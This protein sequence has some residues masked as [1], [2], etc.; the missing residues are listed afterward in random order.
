MRLQS[1]HALGGMEGILQA[2]VRELRLTEHEERQGIVGLQPDGFLCRNQ[3]I[4]PLPLVAKR[5]AA[6]PVRP[7][8]I[9]GQRDSARR[10]GCA[11]GIT[12]QVEKAGGE[13]AADRGILG[14]GG[15]GTLEDGN[16]LALPANRHQRR[17]L[18]DGAVRRSAQTSFLTFM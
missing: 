9:R 17:G 8:G 2:P 5:E 11:F 15:N 13:Q 12:A 14:L 3:G 18:L 7:G 1:D 10:H 6:N 16:G 4:L